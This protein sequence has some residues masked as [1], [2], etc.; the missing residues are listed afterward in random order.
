[1]KSDERRRDAIYKLHVPLLPNRK[2]DVN[3]VSHGVVRLSM[4]D[5]NDAYPTADA[6]T[7]RR[8]IQEHL[9]YN[10]GLLHFLQNDEAVPPKVQEEARQ[11]GLCRDEFQE[12]DHI[13]PQLYIR[14]ARRMVG[15]Y[16]YTERDTDS[17]PGEV[18]ARLHPDSI[19]ISDYILNCHGTGRTGTRFDGQHQ[20]EFYKFVQPSQ[21]PYGVIVPTKT[22]NLLVPVAV[23]SS[24]VGFSMLRYE[25]V[26]MSL[27]Q[28]AGHAA[29]LSLTHD[30]P[31]QDVSIAELQ[32]LIHADNGITIYVADVLP[33]SEDFAAVQWLGTHGFFHGLHDPQGKPIPRP[34][35][36]VGQYN[37][38]F[39]LHAV[40][41]EKP[42]DERTET[43]WRGLAGSLGISL[44]QPAEY[45]GQERGKML[46]EIDRQR[47][48]MR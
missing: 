46:R 26:W 37:E 3:D 42:L 18:R 23:S 1:M 30:L 47:S 34:K 8:I 44:E 36:L 10:V 19:A 22:T 25:P 32:D 33:G 35:T 2:A 45:V 15:Q 14:E 7:R 16:V 9:D 21:I 48:Q 31:V 40:E 28:A 38:A 5:I 27:G 13:P 17:P 43:H 24:H 29:H 6:A 20:G 39:P 12:S 41:L 4:P 11:W